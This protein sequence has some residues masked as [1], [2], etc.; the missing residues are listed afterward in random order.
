MKIRFCGAADGVTGSCHL[1]STGK[2]NFLLDCGL[3]QGNRKNRMK[4][5]RPFP[6]D[7]AEIDF[8]ILSHAHVDHCGRLPLLV[9]QGFGGPVYCTDA[10]ADLT[11]IIL[12]DCA[13]I[14]ERDTEYKNKK[15][16]RSGMPEEKPFYSVNDAIEAVRKLRPLLYGGKYEIEEGITVRFTD[17]GHIFGASSVE[18]WIREK[19]DGEETE[20]KLVFSGDIGTTGRPILR[21]PEKVDGAD[22]V[23]ME[24]TYGDRLHQEKPRLQEEFADAVKKTISRG[25]TVIMPAFAVGRTQEILYEIRMLMLNDPEFSELLKDVKVYVDSPM[26]EA[27]TDVYKKNAQVFDEEAREIILNGI[28]P[29]NFDGLVFTRDVFDSRELNGRKEPKIIIA[30]SGMCDAGR[31]KHHLKHTLWDERNSIIFTGYQAEGTLGRMI[32]DGAEY[33]RIFGTIVDVRAEIFD[34]GGFSAH[35]DREGLLKWLSDIQPKPE[36][37]FLVHGEYAAKNSFAELVEKRLG[38]SVTPV[39]EECGVDTAD[40]SAGRDDLWKDESWDR[41]SKILDMSARLSGVRMELERILHFDPS[42]YPEVTDDESLRN[43]GNMILQLEKDVINLGSAI[44]GL[45]HGV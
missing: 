26:A 4:N 40:L 41:E 32:L 6:F 21:D 34:L 14:N 38:I 11:N 3:F 36:Q 13:Y 2:Y 25:G 39:H 7:P 17:S 29:L 18:L 43:I 10:T 22:I 23:I 28:D 31:I 16:L 9:K 44:S 12:R 35:A 37:V 8:V 24:S 45:R 15:N 5:L 27:A 19:A 42:G 30:S 20:K 33:V 1:I